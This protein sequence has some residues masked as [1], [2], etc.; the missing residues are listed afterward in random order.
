MTEIRG[1]DVECE[2]M[3]GGMLASIRGSICPE[4][5]QRSFAYREGRGDLAFGLR[6]QW[7]RRDLVCPQAADVR[8]SADYRRRGYSAP[9]IAKLEKPQAIKNL[10]AILEVAD[11]VMVARGDLGVEVAP[12]KVPLIQK[13]VIRRALELRASRSSRPRRCSIP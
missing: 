5:T 7:M 4:G 6:T 2:V 8:A 13:H 1:D 11:G 12:E 10:E 3:D 9:V